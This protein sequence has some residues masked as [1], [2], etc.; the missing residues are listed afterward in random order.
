M[1]RT[2]QFHAAAGFA[3]AVAGLFLLAVP[4]HAASKADDAKPKCGCKRSE[5]KH[6]KPYRTMKGYADEAYSLQTNAA[7]RMVQ[8]DK[9]WRDLASRKIELDTL[10]GN[11]DTLLKDCTR[12]KDQTAESDLKNA[13][14]C[15]RLAGSLSGYK[16]RYEELSKRLDTLSEGLAS[17]REAKERGMVARTEFNVLEKQ[18][19]TVYSRAD[20]LLATSYH[21][22]CVNSCF[23]DYLE[24]ARK[25][26]RDMKRRMEEDSGDLK[27]ADISGPPRMNE[28]GS[29]TAEE[30][31]KNTKGK[32]E[33]F[34]GEF[35][36]DK[37]P[38]EGIMDWDGLISYLQ[39]ISKPRATVRFF[40]FGA[41]YETQLVKHDDSVRRPANPE[42]SGY[43]FCFWSDRNATD[44]KAFPGFGQAIDGDLD[45][46]A[47]FGYVIRVEGWDEEFP[48]YVTQQ[49]SVTFSRVFNDP[50]FQAHRSDYE[51]ALKAGHK[52]LDGWVESG[53]TYEIHPNTPIER[54]CTIKGKEKEIIFK[55]FLRDD[56]GQE[57]GEA[58]EVRGG[59]APGQVDAPPG[60]PGFTFRHWSAAR[61]GEEKWDGF[62]QPMEGDFTIYAVWEKALTVTLHPTETEKFIRG[63]QE[64]DVF[65]AQRNE[66]PP[67]RPG[68]KFVCWVDG[69]GTPFDGMKVM[70]DT[71]LYPDFRKETALE[72]IERISDQWQE[73]YPLPFVAGAD[74]ALLVLFS[75]LCLG[76]RNRK[77]KAKT[78]KKKEESADNAP[79]GDAASNPPPESTKK[80]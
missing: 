57:I 25:E 16:A 71:D 10:S 41:P 42:K 63:F 12:A 58:I 48:V 11:F 13:E 34:P 77:K 68:F 21:M 1:K 70:K 54:S 29:R 74:G 37:F 26:F 27:V 2:T 20:E 22:D 17:W 23:N 60:R 30:D 31:I 9:A 8:A 33:K 44:K 59:T 3:A 36:K 72:S 32:I 75:A 46:D 52:S 64:G 80:A 24:T 73:K 50:R 67:E 53:T 66:V 6:I 55:L 61:G 78:P 43:E 79:E 28:S 15:K 45:L 56:L 19:Q 5:D 49:E 18:F 62:D 4:V 69:N 40:V 39:E 47:V 7:A 51:K 65:H 76:G 14:V 35:A 38:G